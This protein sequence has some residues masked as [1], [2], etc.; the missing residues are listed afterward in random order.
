MQISDS[1][2]GYGWASIALHWAVFIAVAT[3]F[4]LGQQLDDLEP[5]S[6]A[7]RAIRGLHV[8]IGMGAAVLILARFFWRLRRGVPANLEG[9]HLTDKLAM[10]VRIALLA[11][12]L[13][14]IVT[15]PLNVWSGGRAIA[16]FDLFAIPS[17]MGRIEWLHEALE[18]IHE[19]AA[20]ALLPLVGLHVLGALKHL[21]LGR[22]GRFQAMLRPRQA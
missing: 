21:V 20:N 11:T 18:E 12:L 4:I 8:S 5:S 7:A 16:F 17:P 10:A 19:I 9:T 3:L 13:V 14:L 15:G 1:N 2:S 6:Q 22:D